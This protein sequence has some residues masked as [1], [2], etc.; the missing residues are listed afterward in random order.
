[1][2]SEK[3]RI[4]SFFFSLIASGSLPQVGEEVHFK[5]TSEFSGRAEREVHVLAEDLRDVGLRDLHSAGEFGLVDAE[6]LHPAKDAAQE[7]R[8][9]MIN[10]F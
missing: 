4:G 3:V 8:A 9:N 10:C 2:K 7:R 6:L 1:M 5:R